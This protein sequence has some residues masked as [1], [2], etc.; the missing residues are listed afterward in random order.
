[1]TGFGNGDLAREDVLWP[2]SVR[3]ERKEGDEIFASGDEAMRGLLSERVMDLSRLDRFSYPTERSAVFSVSHR[4][5]V[6]EY[7]SNEAMLAIRLRARGRLPER[8]KGLQEPTA[9]HHQV[10]QRSQQIFAVRQKERE[11]PREGGMVDS[12]SLS[13]AFQILAL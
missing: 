5:N 13:Q 4:A 12:I 8:F 6:L 9:P 7:P 2:N 1:L 3:E 10:H 11:A